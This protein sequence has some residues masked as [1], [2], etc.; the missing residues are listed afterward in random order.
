MPVPTVPRRAGPPRKKPAKP[1]SEIPEAREEEAIAAPSVISKADDHKAVETEKEAIVIPEHKEQII[2]DHQAEIHDEP[3]SID[4]DAEE[5]AASTK[6]QGPARDIP[7]PDEPKQEHEH[8][9]EHEGEH[10]GPDNP[11][12]DVDAVREEAEDDEQS[13]Y[14]EKPLDERQ[15]WHLQQDDD[16]HVGTESQPPSGA[17]G[18]D[19]DAEEEEDNV[20]E[21]LSSEESGSPVVS[22]QASPESVTLP[23][24]PSRPDIP[25]RRIS[26][27]PHEVAE[28]QPLAEEFK[29]EDEDEQGEQESS[30]GK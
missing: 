26:A 21:R 16:H 17:T 19:E 22:S 14:E 4:S 5:Q 18:T 30:D 20:A 1:S 10:V 27:P 8:E 2:N 13:D 23:V 3:R 28:P 6:V 24:S 29:V 9:H 12:D 11:D 7:L 15:H 25:T